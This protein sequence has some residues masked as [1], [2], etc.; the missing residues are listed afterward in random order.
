MFNKGK[1]KRAYHT[2]FK[3]EIFK[4]QGGGG[5]LTEKKQGFGRGGEKGEK[6][7]EGQINLKEGTILL[8]KIVSRKRGECMH[9]GGEGGQNQIPREQ[10]E[11]DREAVKGRG[12]LK[13]IREEDRKRGELVQMRGR[14]PL[15]EG[16]KKGGDGVP[17][18]SKG[19]TVSFKKGGK[20]TSHALHKKGCRGVAAIRKKRKKSKWSLGFGEDGHFSKGEVR[21]KG[22]GLYPLH[23]GGGKDR[24][25]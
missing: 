15:L 11:S 24:V 6:L 16:G 2:F 25:L 12:F 23:E 3:E 7:T 9:T 10:E 1:K 8:Q 13:K 14:Q 18:R 4:N 21:K 20:E 22:G 17:H 19:V 5:V